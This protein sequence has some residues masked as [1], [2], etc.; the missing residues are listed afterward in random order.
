MIIGISSL[1]KEL[2]KAIE[3]CKK[4]E[5]INHI[6]IGIDNLTECIEVLKYKN[7]FERNSISI[8]IHLPLELN[9][10]ENIDYIRNSWKDFIHEIELGL[11]QIEVKYYN[12]HLGY[13]I[14]SRFEKNK[15]IYLNNS[16]NFLKSINLENKYIFIEN[17][18]TNSGDICNIGTKVCDFEYI[19]NNVGNIEFCYD[20]GHNLINK[21]DFLRLKNKMNLIHLSDNNGKKDLH[22]GLGRG[23]LDLN[24]L[25]NLRSIN[26]K[27]LVLE[28]KYEYIEESIKILER[29]I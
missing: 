20:T 15:N 26:P 17:T 22:I 4:N 10:C 3:I 19:L 23:V 9:T 1:V 16:I 8:G 12:M 18:Y 24:I 7:E 6:E 11:K 28:I 5:I 14:T 25:K 2:D 21:G 27:Y 29:F 13:A